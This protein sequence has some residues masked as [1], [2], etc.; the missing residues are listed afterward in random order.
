VA[1][2]TNHFQHS[3]PCRSLQITILVWTG[4]VTLDYRNYEL[5]NNSGESGF[6]E[7]TSQEGELGLVRC[8][9]HTTA[10]NIHIN[11]NIIQR[12]IFHHNV[13]ISVLS[14][15]SPNSFTLVARRRHALPFAAERKGLEFALHTFG[16][17]H[18]GISSIGKLLNMTTS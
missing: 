7:N 15:V 10:S 14:V 3:N 9:F 11:I 2:N 8:V 5:G 16:N 18:H 1:A 17:R 4:I 13:F 12:T 6:L